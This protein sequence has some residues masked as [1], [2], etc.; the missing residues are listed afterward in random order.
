[1]NALLQMQ[2]FFFI[3]SIGFVIVGILAAIFLFYLIRATNTFSR[4]LEK[5]E[6]DIN[7]I[8]DATKE[9]LDDMRDSAVFNF[10][11]GKK[12]KHRKD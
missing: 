5:A 6:K 1:M 10:L 12:R 4:I 8:G 2:V 9:V 3:S 11:F 7:D